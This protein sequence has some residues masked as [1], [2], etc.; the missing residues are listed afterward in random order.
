M[1]QT[2]F[3]TATNAHDV[4]D[5]K[6]CVKL[7]SI[8]TDRERIMTRLF[9]GEQT[10]RNIVVYFPCSK[11]ILLSIRLWSTKSITANGAA[12]LRSDGIEA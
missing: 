7:F 10:R 11:R 4:L 6:W 12:V 5:G 9:S 3:S 1:A 8:D 2:Q